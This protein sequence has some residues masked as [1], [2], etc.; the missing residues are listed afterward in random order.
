VRTPLAF[1]LRD[2]RP[3]VVRGNASEILALTGA[4]SGGR[5]VDSSDEVDAALAAA[6]DLAGRTGGIVAVSGPVDM[7]TDGHDVIRV[8]NG[9]PLLTRVTGGGCALGAVMAVF[10]AVDEDALATTVA[11]TTVYTIAAEIAAEGASGS[12]GFAVAF[13][14]ALSSI[15][16]LDIQARAVL[17]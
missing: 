15:T 5:G 4:G 9:S 16:P 8:A 13:L 6:T 1:A 2:L 3:T 7:I 10:A 11:A 17:R 14:D 12:G